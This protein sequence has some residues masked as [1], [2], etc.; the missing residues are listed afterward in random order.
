MG[1]GLMI[2]KEFFLHVESYR[3]C[4]GLP[5]MAYMNQK[6]VSSY[7][8]YT[9]QALGYPTCRS[10]LVVLDT[11][12]FLD[13]GFSSCAAPA[14]CCGPGI[15]SCMQVYAL[16]KDHREVTGLTVPQK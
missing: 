3:W 11:K 5:A 10:G 1:L 6:A 14:F 7:I 13:R 4:A 2:W 8:L 15:S 16:P 9:S 12:G